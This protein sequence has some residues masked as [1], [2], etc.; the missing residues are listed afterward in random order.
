M[1][2]EVINKTATALKGQPLHKAGLDAM[3]RRRMFFYPSFEIYGGVKGLYDYGPPGTAL[4]SNLIDIWKKHFILEENMLEVDCTILTPG[5]VLQASGHV[6]KFTDWMCRDA[7]TRD[8]FRANHFVVDMLKARLETGTDPGR[9]RKDKLRPVKLDDA[10]VKEYKEII[11]QIDSCDGEQLGQ[12]IQKHDLRYSRSHKSPKPPVAFNLMF[13]TSIRSGAKPFMNFAKLLEYNNYVMP[14][15]SASI[16]KSFRNEISPRGSLLRVREFLMAEIEHFVDPASGKKHRRFHEVEDIELPFLDRHTQLSGQ[17]IVQKIPVGKAVED[18]IID[19]ETLGYFLARICLFLEKIG[20]DMQKLRFRQHKA[21][22]ACDCWDAELLTSSGWIECVGCADRSAYD[23]DVHSKE[24]REPLVVSEKLDMPRR[25]QEWVVHIQQKKFG[26]FFQKDNNTVAAAIYDLT[27]EQREELSK[28]M[29]ETGKIVL[30]VPGLEKKVEVSQDLLIIKLHS[31]KE[32]VR[33]YTPNVIEPSFGIGRLIYA[34]CEHN[35]WT[36]ADEGPD[37]ARGVLSFPPAVAPTKVAIAPLSAHAAF[38]PYIARLS[39]KLRAA[40][41]SYGISYSGTKLGKRYARNDELG[42][43]LVI[44]LDFQTIKDKTIALRDRDTTS[45]VRAD[46]DTVFDAIQSIVNGSRT[47]SE[48]ENSLPTFE[49]QEKDLPT[50]EGQEKD[51]STLED[52]EN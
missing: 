48:V 42:T 13:Q 35:F 26:S 45:Q 52:Q 6:Q 23:L 12:I 18:G 31:R 9:K 7:D 27:Q 46:E 22:Y 3:L 29:K 40:H 5:L 2:E 44:T 25:V 11:A 47:W 28:E 49:G 24:T 10:V 36:R 37:S 15:A 20:V 19:N 30:D 39:T 33:T 51:S 32:K 34:I 50:P 8:L 14:F 41:I 17:T 43:P 4:Q 16:G 21:H 38:E 1:K